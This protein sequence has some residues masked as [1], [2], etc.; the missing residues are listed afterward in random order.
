MNGIYGGGWEV[1]ERVQV[2]VKTLDEVLKDAS[3]IDLLKI[4]VQGLEAS[5]LRGAVEVLGRTRLLLIECNF[6]SHYVG[7]SLFP[8]LHSM[9]TQAGMT[10]YNVSEP[11]RQSGRALW[12]DALYVRDQLANDQVDRQELAVPLI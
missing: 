11:V 9:L 1:R 5:V 10:L 3:H 12:A 7:D 2:E 6:A 4:D 8:D